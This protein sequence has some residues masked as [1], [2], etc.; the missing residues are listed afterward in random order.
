V[1][2]VGFRGDPLDHSAEEAIE[3]IEIVALSGVV[4]RVGKMPTDWKAAISGQHL[5]SVSCVLGCDHQSFAVSD[6][7]TFD[8]LVSLEVPAQHKP[9][10]KVCIWVTRG[11]L[12]PGRITTL[13]ETDLV[14]K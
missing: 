4:Y 3:Q 6:I 8:G 5:D 11:P 12:G 14:L 9:E 13:D 10:I 1:V 2:S 7:H